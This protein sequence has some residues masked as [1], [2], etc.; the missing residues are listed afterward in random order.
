MSGLDRLDRPTLSPT[1][2]SSSS[3]RAS[4]A[5]SARSGSPRRA[6]GSACSRPA[7]GSRTRTSPTTSFDLQNY[8][9][10]PEIG[11]YGIQRIDA[12]RDCLIL[13]GAGVGGGSLVYANTLYEPLAPFYDDPQWRDITDWQ[14]ELAPYYDQAKR[15][16]GVV[17]NPVARPPT[18]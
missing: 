1:T 18:R 17:D 5:R 3:A 14:E 10:R 8:L 11:C 9:F 4:A 12:L 15:M 6:T 13:S 2:T 16:L 7:P